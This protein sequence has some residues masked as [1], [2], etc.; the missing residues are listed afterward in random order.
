LADGGGI[1]LSGTVHEHIKNKMELEYQHLG[2]QT[3]KNIAQPVEVYRVL[4]YPGA[5]AHR[6]IK[7]IMII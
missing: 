6:V 5:A 7:A 2:K 4:S 3:V 1:C